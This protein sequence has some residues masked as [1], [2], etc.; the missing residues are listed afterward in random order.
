M[1]AEIC[2]TTP[3][4]ERV[5]QEDVGIA[6][7]RHH[8]FLDARAAGIV[9]PDDRRAQLER[10]VHDLD[11]LGGVG[12]RQRPAED[13]EVLGEDEDLTAFDQAVSRDDAVAGNQLL[14][15]AEVAATVCD[16]PVELFEGPGIVEQLDPLASGQ[17][18][19]GVLALEPIGAAAKL[20]APIEV[21]E[22]VFWLHRVDDIML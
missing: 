15:H 18:A 21:G 4:D 13:R 19:G 2:G 7:E 9:Q 1:I 11:D 20:G 10:Q 5:A 17:L 3:D 16:Q 14:V 22:D 6:A 8:A 12:L